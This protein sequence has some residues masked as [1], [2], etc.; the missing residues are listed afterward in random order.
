MHECHWRY[1][2]LMFKKKSNLICHG[3]WLQL[4]MKCASGLYCS[5]YMLRNTSF[6]SYSN[7]SV[8]H[9]NEGDLDGSLKY[10][11]P[12]LFLELRSDQ[13]ENSVSLTTE[14]TTWKHVTEAGWDEF[15]EQF[16]YI[17]IK[18]Y[19]E[20]ELMVQMGF[21]TSISQEKWISVSDHKNH[22]YILNV[23]VMSIFIY[24]IYKHLLIRGTKLQTSFATGF[25]IKSLCRSFVSF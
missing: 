8:I 2:V 25:I 23:F 17:L 14:T 7:L 22:I 24:L 10:A 1:K 9:V 15:S 16:V 6:C 21:K 18:G 20:C 13:F 11:Y 5:F 19:L 12:D 3:Q 4:K